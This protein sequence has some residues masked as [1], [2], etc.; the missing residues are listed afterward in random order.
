MSNGL[1][2]VG[3]DSG[4]VADLAGQPE[5]TLRPCVVLYNK[6]AF[7]GGKKYEK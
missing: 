3:F 5:N 1:E 7:H 4:F 6:D 2:F